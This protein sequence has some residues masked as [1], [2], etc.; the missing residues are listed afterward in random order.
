MI[1]LER[2]D[3][4]IFIARMSTE[5]GLCAAH[6]PGIGIKDAGNCRYDLTKGAG[7]WIL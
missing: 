4:S 1:I 5:G 2:N 6:E 7:L 3:S